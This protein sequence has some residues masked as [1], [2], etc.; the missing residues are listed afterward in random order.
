MILRSKNNILDYYI[1]DDI[2]FYNIE[3]YNIKN[4]QKLKKLGII[5]FQIS[6]IND[7][8]RILLIDDLFVEISSLSFEINLYTQSYQVICI[9]SNQYQYEIIKSKKR[10]LKTFK[11]LLDKKIKLLQNH[12]LENSYLSIIKL[13]H[14]NKED[15]MGNII[16]RDK[17][18]YCLRIKDSLELPRTY[19]FLIALNI[20]LNN[21]I[22]GE[23]ENLIK[24]F[25]IANI[26]GVIIF[27]IY[28]NKKN[29]ILNSYYF[30]TSD[31]IIDL[32]FKLKDILNGQN[33]KN[34]FFPLL[35]PKILLRKKCLNDYIKLDQN[36]LFY[37]KKAI[38]K[39]NNQIVN[40]NFRFLIPNVENVVAKN[41]NLNYYSK[42]NIY[43]REINL[44]RLFKSLNINVSKIGKDLFLIDNKIL[45]INIYKG[46]EPPLIKK[47]LNY[48]QQ[49]YEFII[50]LFS[51][52]QLL[53][54]FIERTRIK[55]SDFKFIKFFLNLNDLKIFLKYFKKNMRFQIS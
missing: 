36:M 38:N 40:Q 14:E 11:E 52:K 44:Q 55:I 9:L 50:F 45:I 53:S 7:F 24:L 32:E 37:I 13:N 23:I 46:I 47:I 12:D 18:S 2:I 54:E 10:I 22:N 33:L 34:R 1:K 5:I 20:G 31:D 42:S 39:T 26:Q 28:K 19:F 35:I 48:I 21:F 16:E 30:T 25:A 29:L 43:Y 49:N 51:N 41:H 15:I 6:D 17:D 4:L 27:N 3:G 8:L